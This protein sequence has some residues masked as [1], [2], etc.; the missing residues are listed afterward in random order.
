MQVT[1]AELD[2]I[3]CLLND[4]Q[5]SDPILRMAFQEVISERHKFYPDPADKMKYIRQWVANYEVG[6]LLHH[7]SSQESNST[8][9]IRHNQYPLITEA[10]PD[11]KVR[12][13]SEE[14][15]GGVASTNRTISYSED[16]SV[17]FI[18]TD[19]SDEKEAFFTPEEWKSRVVC[20]GPHVCVIDMNGHFIAALVCHIEKAVGGESTCGCFDTS[21]ACDS[22][23]Y[24]PALI[25]FQTTETNYMNSMSTAWTFDTFHGLKL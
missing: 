19:F 15:F 13:V 7:H 9:F 24:E 8:H 18:Q 14:R 17:Y 22:P 23:Q 12:L 4:P 25:L 1:S 10:T 3:L 5:N 20:H 16:S 21:K 2:E 6:D 11:E